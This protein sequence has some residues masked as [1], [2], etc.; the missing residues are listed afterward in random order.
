MKLYIHSSAIN[1]HRSFII[2]MGRGGVGGHI[3]ILNY[4][5]LGGGGHLHLKLFTPL[6]IT[7]TVIKNIYKSYIQSVDKH[8]KH[9]CSKINVR[10]KHNS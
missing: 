4:S 6:Q 2:C 1:K 7:N 8:T 3:Y 9:T 5:P 10:M